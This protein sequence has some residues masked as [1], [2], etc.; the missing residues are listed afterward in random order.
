MSLPE[1]RDALAGTPGST[2]TVSVVRARKAEPQKMV[3]TRDIVTIPP[4]PTRCWKMA[5]AI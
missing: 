4:S 5:S 3:I 1:I 2:V